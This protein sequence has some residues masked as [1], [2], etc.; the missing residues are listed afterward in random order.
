MATI[1]I[2]STVGH[3]E[4]LAIAGALLEWCASQPADGTLSVKTY[5]EH[6]PD[7]ALSISTNPPLRSV[8]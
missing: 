4:A 2:S 5:I 8:K 7:G 3:S 1:T 6:H